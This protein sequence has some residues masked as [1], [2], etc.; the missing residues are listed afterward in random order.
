[1]FWHTVKQTKQT[2]YGMDVGA[3]LLG[4]LRTEG[5]V[6]VRGLLRSPER[7]H[8]CRGRGRGTRDLDGNQAL[9]LGPEVG[10]GA[11][12]RLAVGQ[13]RL[14]DVVPEHVAR[15][16]LRPNPAGGRGSA[17]SV[18]S[19]PLARRLSNAWLGTERKRTGEG[20]TQSVTQATAARTS[21]SPSSASAAKRPGAEFAGLSPRAR[22][23]R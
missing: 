23:A 14:G 10:R 15:R 1:M 3:R 9:Q 8:R 12:S 20:W 7:L 5:V 19:K 17:Q 21:T 11:V 22:A 13:A 18:S 2:R 4:S 6:D 16:P